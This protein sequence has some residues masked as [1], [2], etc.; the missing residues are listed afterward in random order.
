MTVTV[1][2]AKAGMVGVA[3]IES[4]VAGSI[5]VDATPTADNTVVLLFRAALQL[6]A[7]T[8]AVRIRLFN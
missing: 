3:N 4:A 7:G 2:G 1:P 6:L 5:T 8:R